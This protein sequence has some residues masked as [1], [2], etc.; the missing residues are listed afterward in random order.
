MTAPLVSVLTTAYNREKYLSECSESV[1]ASSFTDFEYIIVDDCSTDRSYDIALV[2]QKILVFVFIAT[3]K[4]SV[5]IRT[6]IV[7]HRLPTENISNTSTPTMS[8]IRMGWRSWFRR[9]SS[10]RKPFLD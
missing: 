3:N 6:A 2:P 10:S 4:I 1:L 8:S 9:W 5:I 7:R